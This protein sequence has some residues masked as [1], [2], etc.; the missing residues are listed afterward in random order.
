MENSIRSMTR[1]ML[2]IMSFEVFYFLVLA[3]VAVYKFDPTFA[4]FIFGWVK[5]L[6]WLWMMIAGTYFIPYQIAKVWR[7]DNVK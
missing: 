4:G 7:S 5:E 3:S 6:F 2:A 1:R